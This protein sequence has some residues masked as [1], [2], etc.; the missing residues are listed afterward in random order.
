HIDYEKCTGCG[1]CEEKCPRKIIWSGKAQSEDG[2]V[3]GHE[4]LR[5]D[6]GKNTKI[7]GE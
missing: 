5:A 2:I 1:I 7:D 4:D 6:L 3:R